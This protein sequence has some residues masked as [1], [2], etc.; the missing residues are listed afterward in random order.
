VSGRATFSDSGQ[1]G[2]WLNGTEVSK[3]FYCPSESSGNFYPFYVG[4]GVLG[5]CPAYELA[6]SM[7][8]QYLLTDAE[9]QRI[10]GYLAWK[11]G[12]RHPLPANHPYKNA[13]P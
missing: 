7:I 10:E 13:S 8:F 4:G 2:V 6:E 5:E 12:L 11:W 9:R 1:Q 3:T